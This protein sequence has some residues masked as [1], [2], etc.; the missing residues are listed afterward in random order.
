MSLV[1]SPLQAAAI[2]LP[3]LCIQDLISILAIEKPIV[4][5][6]FNLASS[7]YVGNNIWLSLV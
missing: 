6:I 2:L 5:K 4:E 7:C 3:I 1:I